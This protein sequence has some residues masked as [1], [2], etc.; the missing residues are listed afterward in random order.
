[1][2]KTDYPDLD[3]HKAKHQ[4]LRLTVA[5]LVADYEEEGETAALD[6]AVDT[7]LG[8][9]LIT[10]IRDTDQAFGWY[11]KEKGIVVPRR[12]ELSTA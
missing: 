1:M 3:T 11:V 6:T 7:F 2:V 8:N 9:W 10:H 4:E 5:N 12:A